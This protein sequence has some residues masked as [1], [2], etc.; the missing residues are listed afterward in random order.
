MPIASASK[1]TPRAR[2]W[3]RPLE[4]ENSRRALQS[5]GS[6]T[7][8]VRSYD[9]RKTIHPGPTTWPHS[10]SLRKSMTT[11][12]YTQFL[13]SKRLS[14]SRDAGNF[15]QLRRCRTPSHEK[16]TPRAYCRHRPLLSIHSYNEPLEAHDDSAH[17][18]S[19]RR[20]RARSSTKRPSQRGTPSFTTY[21]PESLAL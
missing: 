17:H 19:S 4:R 10:T 7:Q 6:T 15:L 9:K 12:P 2:F 21:E 11:A 14:S 18:R 20:R 8:S 5:A 13:P 16:P 3:H 1:T